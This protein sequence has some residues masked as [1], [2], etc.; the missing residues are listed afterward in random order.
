MV[1]PDTYI[2][3]DPSMGHTPFAF[4]ANKKSAKFRSTLIK[5]AIHFLVTKSMLVGLLLASQTTFVAP[6]KANVTVG[7]GACEQTVGNAT[8]VT[9]TQVGNDCVVTFTNAG[10]SNSWKVP[11]SVTTISMLVV[12]GG[13]GGN[14]GI[15]GQTYGSGS[16]GGAVRFSNSFLVT[17]QADIA[18]TVGSGGA[19]AQRNC[20]EA[21]PDSGTNGG[22]SS[23][24]SITAN[25]GL[26]SL[27]TSI[28]GGSSGSE[29]AGGTGSATGGNCNVGGC[30]SGGGGGAGSFGIGDRGGEGIISDITGSSLPYGMGAPGITSGVVGRFGSVDHNSPNLIPPNSGAG[31]LDWTPGFAG[32]V[33]VRYTVPSSIPNCQSTESTQSGEITQTISTTGICNWTAPQGVT[34]IKF[35]LIGGGGGGGA[36]VG[37]GGGG[38]GVIEDLDE[39]VSPGTSYTLNV[40]SGGLGTVR[41]NSITFQGNNGGSTTG[42][43][44]TALGGG[45]GASWVSYQTGAGGSG[46]GGALDSAFESG[47][48]AG[49]LGTAGQGSNGG[50]GRNVSDSIQFGYP[51]GGGGGAGGVGGTASGGQSGAG[52]VGRVSTIT[53]GTYGGGGGGGCHGGGTT[54]CVNGGGG[55]GG[56]GSGAGPGSSTQGVDGVAGTANTGGGGGGA[57][58]TGSWYSKG[59]NG[60]S[61]LIVIKY[62]TAPAISLSTSTINATVGTSVT[63]YTI[64][65]TGGPVTSYSISPALEVAGLSFSTST[66]QISGTPTA[67]ASSTTYTI[68]ATNTSGTS[69]ATFTISVSLAGCSPT[70]DTSSVPGYTI[71]KFTSVGSCNWTVPSG[72]SSADVL[73][74]GGGGGGGGTGNRGWSGGGG[75]GGDVVSSQTLNITPQSSISITVGAGGAGGAGGMNGE[76][77][78]DSDFAQSGQDSSFG[79]LIAKGGGKGSD[80]AES[81]SYPDAPLINAFPETDLGA[82]K[83]GGGGSA[84]GGFFNGAKRDGNEFFG[85]KG[86]ASS[87]GT[88]QAGGGG[89]GAA[90]NGAHATSGTGGNGGSGAANS[91]TGTQLNY[92]GGGGGGKRT[93][94]TSGT[95]IH[96]GGNGGSASSGSAGQPNTGGGGGGGGGDANARGGDGSKPPPQLM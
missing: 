87:T 77:R 66:G 34:R 20:N 96:G 19:A 5:K 58:N 86:F 49:G 55:S 44:F 76:D 31:G 69:T 51:T 33:I 73:V 38:G 39:V 85:G 23:F 3:S 47:R 22:N 56:G 70:P 28:V 74:V 46:G 60:G 12:G 95:G 8:G 65:N 81:T 21:N 54:A 2:R 43:G 48:F 14:R 13:G 4:L 93:A 83:N 26:A 61:G 91:I 50:S 52:G 62:V 68:T 7:S 6:A 72:V 9:V 59:G 45:L 57:G 53:G 67:A 37:G 16:G 35:L 36:W 27:R 78:S 88:P 32:V 29:N 15:C 41:N 1:L 63:S 80:A 24:G 84:Q 75:A 18:L 25:G 64:T 42:F 30:G 10:A 92:G 11:T 71:L 17:P 40:G 82:P 89:A 94:G 79:N 90:G